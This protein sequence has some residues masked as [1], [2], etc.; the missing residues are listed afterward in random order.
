MIY[1]CTH[2]CTLCVCHSVCLLQLCVCLCVHAYGCVGVFECGVVCVCEFL[3]SGNVCVV[4]EMYESF[5]VSCLL[6]FV[7]FSHCDTGNCNVSS[8]SVKVRLHWVLIFVLNQSTVD[9]IQFSDSVW[10]CAVSFIE[11]CKPDC[12]SSCTFLTLCC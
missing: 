11:T 2:I 4:T 10:C 7:S 5:L 1:K 9:G 6:H 3:N 8:Y 12:I